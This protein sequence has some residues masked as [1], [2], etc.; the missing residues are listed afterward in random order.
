[1]GEIDMRKFLESVVNQFQAE[2]L[3]GLR[4][5][6]KDNFTGKFHSDFAASRECWEY[7][8]TKQFPGLARLAT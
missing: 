6:L 4:Y 1:M 7:L 5:I 3:D 2:D 8:I